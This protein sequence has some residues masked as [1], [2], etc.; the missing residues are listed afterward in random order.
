VPTE[1]KQDP[2]CG[3][4][5]AHLISN[6]YEKD[7]LDNALRLDQSKQDYIK[8]QKE[9]IASFQSSLG[10]YYETN[11]N[12]KRMEANTKKLKIISVNE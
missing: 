3:G 11:A 4:S 6:Q 9:R 1:Q 7:F 10:P 2:I 12:R 5:I 8:R